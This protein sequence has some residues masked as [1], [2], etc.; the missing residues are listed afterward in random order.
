MSTIPLPERPD[1]N[2]LRTQ[3]K[4]LR[5]AAG[6]DA[7]L[8]D[9]QRELARRHGF[10]SWPRLRRHVEAIN[11]RTWSFAEATGDEPLTDRFLRLVCLNFTEDEVDRREQAARLLDQHPDL[12]AANLAVAAVCADAEQVRQHLA[13]GVSAT[14]PSGPYDWSPLMYLA[15]AR[16]VGVGLEATL[17]SARL[18]LDAGADPNDGRF[19][20]GLPTPF[21][22]LTG[23]LGGGEDD[24]PPH[25]H[26]IPLARLLLSR[27]ADPNDG[28]TLYN[29]MFSEEDDFLRLLLGFGLGRGDGGPWRRL[30]PDMID[31]PAEQLRS[32]LKWAVTHNQRQRVALL[33][34]HGVDVITPFPD[35]TTPVRLAQRN[36]HR[37]LA[38]FLRERGAPTP[39]LEPVETFIAAVLAVDATAVA[40]T[41][42]DVV[43]AAREARPGL[44]VWAT[45]LGRHDA[46]KLLADNGFDVNAR[47]RGDMPVEQPWQT[48]LHSAV[49]T[50]DVE[51]VR[52][53]LDLGADPT[54]RDG[55]FDGDAMSWAEHFGRTEIA[56][57][58]AR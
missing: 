55:R 28:Q 22:V 32:L 8:S 49:E 45:A 17:N 46:V 6:P 15:Y 16:P 12:P 54:I 47:S 34:E 2:Q 23:V 38:R 25:P 39:E 40:A 18:L 41:P 57:M 50:G 42:P 53:L 58:L 4:E 31:T 11:A 21:T 52:L 5:R 1:L 27:G 24:Q 10:A 48:A 35:G 44:M 56:E 9:A 13:S 7:T 37:K 33:A 19:F 3:A 14:T 36:G 29:R 30:L 20:L 43:A 51:M 26:S